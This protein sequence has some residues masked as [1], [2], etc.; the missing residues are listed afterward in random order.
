MGQPKSDVP[1]NGRNSDLVLRN[2]GSFIFW[3][4]ITLVGWSF[5]STVKHET[6]IAVME[7]RLSALEDKVDDLKENGK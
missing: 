5:Y 7:Q 1:G 3:A 6:A 4:V 2:V